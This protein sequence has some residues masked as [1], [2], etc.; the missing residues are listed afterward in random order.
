MPKDKLPLSPLVVHIAD[1]Y[2]LVDR[3]F[4]DREV[5]WTLNGEEVASGYFGRHD[6]ITING[7]RLQGD[8]AYALKYSGKLVHTERNDSMGDEW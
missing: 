4:G 8:D 2:D 6:Y 5:T 7:L 3:A 1:R